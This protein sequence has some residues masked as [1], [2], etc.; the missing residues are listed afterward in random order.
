MAVE[1]LLSMI[2]EVLKT[3]SK[4][5]DKIT[6]GVWD[7]I[8][9]K[10]YDKLE[11]DSLGD[12]ERIDTE[13]K[14]AISEKRQEF[15]T[16]FGDE[17][18]MFKRLLPPGLG[19]L[20]SMF[21][22]KKFEKEQDKIDAVKK[23]NLS[24]SMGDNY[25]QS[26]KDGG[27][28][29][30]GT[31]EP[32]LINDSINYHNDR[33]PNNPVFYDGDKTSYIDKKLHSKLKEMHSLSQDPTN[34]GVVK[35]KD[36]DK[37]KYAT[38]YKGGGK[39][40]GITMDEKEYEYIR[41][42]KGNEGM[43]FNDFVKGYALGGFISGAGT[44]KSDSI[45]AT[46]DAG[47]FVVA[48][49]APKKAV[50]AL[51]KG[52]GSQ[53]AS[54]TTGNTKVK[55]SNGEYVVKKQATPI[56]DALLKDIGYKGGLNDLVKK[57]NAKI[58]K[59]KGLPVKGY[60]NTSVVTRE[61][62]PD[63]LKSKN[64]LVV[65]REP[66]PNKLKI[67]R[68]PPKKDSKV[69]DFLKE[70]KNLIPG[71]LQVGAGLYQSAKAGKRPQLSVPFE[72]DSIKRRRSEDALYGL[73]PVAKNAAMAAINRNRSTSLKKIMDSGYS[74][75]G[76]LNAMN[77]VNSSTNDAYINLAVNDTAARDSKL[78]SVDTINQSIAATKQN[79]QKDKI[80]QYNQT[81]SNIGNMINAGILNMS[82][83]MDYKKV[84]ESLKDL[85]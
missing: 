47:D 76:S 29:K 69:M 3:A 80:D 49:D 53:E 31:Y 32:M 61:P 42:S 64:A 7:A 6:G 60:K 85:K 58:T 2:P 55:L 77:D 83:S 71:A 28:V 12:S 50:E 15:A 4:V 43:M 1:A 5:R 75:A 46:L 38:G 78:L 54:K 73:D 52:L 30:E 34:G 65:A 20:V 36:G 14:L 8:Q 62:T 70:N 25:M 19:S 39:I 33:N 84:I 57:P 68:E 63:K 66:I 35:Y 9:K 51:S 82:G 67:K 21:K 74:G 26:L 13:S 40:E 23:G 24:S 17:L 79:M 81:Q 45:K 18:G 10:D 72:L 22:K 11:N 37:Y 44:G 56:A 48:T 41:K 59:G 27:K 16:S